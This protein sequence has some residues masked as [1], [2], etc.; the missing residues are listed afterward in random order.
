M[1]NNTRR[2]F[3]KVAGGGYAGYARGGGGCPSCAPPPL[4]RRPLALRTL[5]P[6]FVS[7]MNPPNVKYHR[8]GSIYPIS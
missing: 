4:P 1:L 6:A 2:W 8:A 3:K 7:V 5:A